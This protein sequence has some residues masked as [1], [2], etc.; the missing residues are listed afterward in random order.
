[1]DRLSLIFRWEFEI[2]SFKNYIIFFFIC[3]LASL[4]CYHVAWKFRG[5]FILRIE[6]CGNKFAARIRTEIPLGTN[7][8]GFLFK[9]QDYFQLLLLFGKKTFNHRERG[10]MWHP[11]DLRKWLT[12]PFDWQLWVRFLTPQRLEK[13]C[14]NLLSFR[15]VCSKLQLLFLNA[16]I[17]INDLFD[18]T[19]CG[20]STSQN[21][22]KLNP[23]K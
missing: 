8:C 17:K 1:M 14:L 2:Q 6:V 18:P 4:Y 7:F 9:R 11:G 22:Q 19:V 16:N 3:L 12:W 15:F 20:S 21:P 23:A 13:Y 5:T 10:K